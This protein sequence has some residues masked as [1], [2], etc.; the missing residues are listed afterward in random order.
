MKHAEY[1]FIILGG[2][3]AGCLLA[4]Q[5]ASHAS[6]LLIE[7]GSA[8]E[9]PFSSVPAYYPR[10][11]GS[12]L[13]W[14]YSTTPQLGLN[15]RSILWPR[16]KG[17]GGSG[18]INALIYMQPALADFDRWALQGCSDWSAQDCRNLLDFQLPS[19]QSETAITCPFSDL[20]LAS[21][22]EPHPWTKQWLDAA[23]A[24]GL[25][26]QEFWVQPKPNVSGL[27]QLTQFSGKRV[28]SGQHLSDLT[29]LT[30]LSDH[31]FVK[32]TLGNNRVQ[33]VELIGP[34]NE[35][36]SITARHRVILCAGTI[37]SPTLLLRSGIGSAEQ[38]SK[39]RIPVQIDLPGVGQNLQDH[40]MFSLV[41]RT[42]EERGLP[43]RF[44]K[45]F[46]DRFRVQ[47]DGPMTSNIAEAGAMFNLTSSDHPEFQIH[48][49]PTHYLKY[50]ITQRTADAFS[51]AITDLHPMSRG[52]LRLESALPREAPRIDPAYLQN[53]TDLARLVEA[54]TWC[55]HQ[56]ADSSL[57][58]LIECE[59][60]PGSKRTGNEAINKVIR[61]FAESIYHPIGTCRMGTDAMSVVSPQLRVHGV[62]NLFVADASVLPDLPSG[63]TNAAALFVA[64]RLANWLR[65]K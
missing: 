4:S 51:I 29:N 48:F 46:R 63:N 30:L 57:A 10:T 45:P 9:H 40:L 28:H 44:G 49:T 38:L 56:I 65:A 3:S 55:R 41:Y 5:L 19:S 6:V 52:S 34:S 24:M 64:H 53:S 25:K 36:V 22:R 12:R 2:G 14:G 27:Y 32:L 42:R 17:L 59:L 23:K 8:I 60:L 26:P 13:D 43:A 11:F 1:A 33:A 16:G 61:T 39:L 21:L 62:E 35:A 50:P 7:A 37:G 58:K 31:E 15:N 47:G 18:A 54:V 20:P